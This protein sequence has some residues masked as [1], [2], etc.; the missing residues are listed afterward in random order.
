MSKGVKSVLLPDCF[1]VCFFNKYRYFIL[2]HLVGDC[3]WF[4]PRSDLLLSNAPVLVLA[5]TSGGTG[6][7][8]KCDGTQTRN[9]VR[10]EQ[11]FHLSFLNV[12]FPST[13]L[14]KMTHCHPSQHRSPVSPTMLTTT[15][16]CLTSLSH[17]NPH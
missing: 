15:Y 13:G 10:T 1:F 5:A 8:N 2:Q 17:L 7:L 4:I 14:R 11:R 12:N 16:A 9:T 6:G 3:V